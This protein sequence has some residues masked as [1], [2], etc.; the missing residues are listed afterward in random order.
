V[1][2]PDLLGNALD[3][4]SVVA[5]LGA[6]V[7]S[8][9]SLRSAQAQRRMAADEHAEFMR[10]LR[11]RAS[12]EISLSTL[13]GPENDLLELPTGA[14]RTYGLIEV[15]LKNTGDRAARRTILNLVAQ[16]WL[17]ELGW[18]EPDGSPRADARSA[19]QTP[20]AQLRDGHGQE[21]PGIYLIEEF[22]SIDRRP[23]Y[24]RRARFLLPEGV[25]TIPFRAVAQ[26]DDLPDE[27]FEVREDFLLRLRPGGDA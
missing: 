6:L 11:A 15:G 24:V 7:I 1:S 5:A 4:V 27:L 2:G 19:M 22:S 3:A 8:L 25:E 17:A 13:N 12:F 20:D 14:S 18:V 23:A 26:S 9:L 16:S 21:H 10:E